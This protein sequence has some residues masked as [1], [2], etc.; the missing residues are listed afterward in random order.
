MA[1]A[2]SPLAPKVIGTPEKINGV[3]FKVGS[4]ELRYKNRPDLLLF[5][6]DQRAVSAGVF[7]R[8][9][10]RAAPVDWSKDALAKTQGKIRAI[11]INAGNANAFTGKAGALVAKDCAIALAKHLSL[12]QE[13]IAIASTGVIGVVPNAQKIIDFLPNIISVKPSQ[14]QDWLN[15]ARAISTTDTFQKLATA[16][17]TIGGKKVRISGIAKGS[18]MIAPD[19]ATMLGF[20]F[21]DATLP[22]PILN[23]LLKEATDQSFNRITVDSDT[24]TNDTL[25]LTASGAVDHAMPESAKDKILK[26][27]KKALLAVMQ[28]LA[29]SI[30]KDGEGAQKL[31]SIRVNGAKSNQSAKKIGFS[32]ANSP[33]V[34]TAIAGEDANWGRIVM[35]VGKSG[36]PADRDLLSIKMGGIMIADKGAGVAFYDEAPVAAHLKGQEI[37]IE[38]DLGIG[39]G[40]SQV[41]TCDLTHG[42][43]DINADYRS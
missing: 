25:L 34:K 10:T 11:L 7:T 40:K 17:T 4:A 27:F 30:V 37:L 1:Y 43:I 9:A 23:A 19:M 28:E 33:L 36:E 5:Q 6:L 39:R 35:A 24:S 14:D 29:L 8:S 22:Y 12:K 26:P 16:V 18:G 42:Y 41:W 31:I 38:V 3:W 21:T 13:E 32:I 20:V 2:V 15:A